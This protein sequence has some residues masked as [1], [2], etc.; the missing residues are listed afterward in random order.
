MS[1]AKPLCLIAGLSPFNARR[2]APPSPEEIEEMASSIM[3]HGVIHPLLLRIEEQKYRVLDGGRRY[4]AAESGR[5]EWEHPVRCLFF[6]GAD[7][8]ALEVSMI[9][10]LHRKDLHPVD[11]FER[12]AELRDAFPADHDTLASSVEELASFLKEAGEDEGEHDLEYFTWLNE[13]W[14]FDVESKRF[15][16]GGVMADDLDADR[17]ATRRDLLK[18][19]GDRVSDALH[20]VLQLEDDPQ[21]RL[22]IAMMALASTMGTTAG[23]FMALHGLNPEEGLDKDIAIYLINETC[24]LRV[25]C[26]PA[27]ELARGG[28][29]GTARIEGIVKKSASPWFSAL[30]S[31]AGRKREVADDRRPAPGGV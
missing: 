12:F 5:I 20:S 6:E 13:F 14:P 22:V 8:Q 19:A 28:I 23:I 10:F 24:A 15:V 16:R 17:A 31:R 18:L 1:D 11:E 3:E 4:F 26:P 2:N 21:E 9:S 27:I 29:I 30:T 7:E 25:A